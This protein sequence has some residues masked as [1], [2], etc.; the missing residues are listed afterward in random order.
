MSGITGLR[1]LTI[2]YFNTNENRSL[3]T[4]QIYQTPANNNTFCISIKTSIAET[5]GTNTIHISDQKQ[6]K[7]YLDNKT[8]SC[9]L[10]SFFSNRAREVEIWHKRM[11]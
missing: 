4:E 9:S 7:K 6:K 2:C 8:L 10:L 3:Q 1:Q 11:H 5:A